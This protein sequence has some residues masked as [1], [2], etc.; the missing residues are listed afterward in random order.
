MERSNVMDLDEFMSMHRRKALKAEEI[1]P[2]PINNYENLPSTGDFLSSLLENAYHNIGVKKVEN[3]PENAAEMSDVSSNED[4]DDT[5]EHPAFVD[6]E[7]IRR[8]DRNEPNLDVKIDDKSK[9]NK[10]HG[11]RRKAR[12]YKYNPKPVQQKTNRSFVPDKL[13]DEEYWE[14]RKRNNQAAKKS[15]EDR[16]RKELEVLEKMAKLEKMNSELVA[17]VDMLEKKN[18]LLERKLK[19]KS[20]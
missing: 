4:E 7:Y 20:S 10:Q 9:F 6:H 11:K 2:A 19:I 15:R 17:K 16:R 3:E 5:N 8:N 18:Q 14:R 1:T 12:T 13:K